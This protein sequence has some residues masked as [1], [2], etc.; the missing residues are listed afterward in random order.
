MKQVK[1]FDKGLTL[2]DALTAG[3]GLFT[4]FMKCTDGCN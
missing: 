1:R 4:S 2:D 3:I